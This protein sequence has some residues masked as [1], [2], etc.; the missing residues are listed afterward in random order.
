MQGGA[1]VPACGRLPVPLLGLGGVALAQ[2]PRQPVRGFAVPLFGGG[3]EPP[4]DALVPAVLQQVGQPVRAQRVAG[5]GRLPHPVLRGGLVPALTEVAAEGVRGGGGSGDGGD[6]PPAGRVLGVAPL[7]EEHAEVVRGGA[8]PFTGGSPQ[9]RFGAVEVAAAQQQRAEHAHGSGV[10]L[11]GGHP[12]PC[13]QLGVA[14]RVGLGEHLL[15]AVLVQELR[16]GQCSLRVDDR[17]RPLGLCV[18][19]GLRP[20]K[21]P[22]LQQS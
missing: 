6:P 1:P 12:V 16:I 10:A 5:L 14:R 3:A 18:R 19:P 13:F 4:L 11:V 20:H 22:C 21:P 2:V 15:R 8:V 9:V 17:S 7:V